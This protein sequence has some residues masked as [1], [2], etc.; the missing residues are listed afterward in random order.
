MNTLHICNEE[1]MSS[2]AALALLARRP[3][4][5]LVVTYNPAC[6]RQGQPEHTLFFAENRNRVKLVLDAWL[7]PGAREEVIA[8]LR[9]EM[10]VYA[11]SCSA[12]Y[13]HGASIVWAEHEGELRLWRRG[14]LVGRFRAGETALRR[15][16]VGPWR[17]FANSHFSCAHGFLSSS[18]L[19]RGVRLQRRDDGAVPIIHSLDP[20]VLFD[21]TYHGP[22]LTRD[23]GWVRDLARAISQA[24]AL[25][26]KLDSPLA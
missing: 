16:Y 1:P 17:R 10:R 2:S 5:T 4:H 8:A 13:I 23:A 7:V 19:W 12:P 9:T 24:T 15:C 22:E 14:R 26:L 11:G 21:P 18:W 3:H 25:P 6:S 20:I